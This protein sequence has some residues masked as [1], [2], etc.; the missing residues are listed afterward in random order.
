[1]IGTA[2]RTARKKIICV[3]KIRQASAPQCVEEIEPHKL[4]NG[5]AVCADVTSG[6]IVESTALV[7]LRISEHY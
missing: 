3:E 4:K 7:S 1:M 5:S 2:V 6:Q